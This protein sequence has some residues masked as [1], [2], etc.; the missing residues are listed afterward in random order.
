MADLRLTSTRLFGHAYRLDLL[1]A[2]AAAGPQGVVITE[3]AKAKTVSASV[4]YPP[5]RALA[6]LDLVARHE[7]ADF[8]RR[9]RYVATQS[10]A[11]EP[12]RALVEY[13]HS[14]TSGEMGAGE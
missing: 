11:W 3:L 13:L 6:E 10:P 1:S 12:L 2:L 4:F 8:S 7:P 9:V 5:V 14:G